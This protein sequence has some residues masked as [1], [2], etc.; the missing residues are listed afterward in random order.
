MLYN[1]LNNKGETGKIRYLI[2]N[3]KTFKAYFFTN[4]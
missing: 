1:Y 2:S 4:R 3:E